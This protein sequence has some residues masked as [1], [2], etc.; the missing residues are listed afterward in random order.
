MKQVYPLELADGSRTAITIFRDNLGDAAPLLLFFPAMGVEAS[1]YQP[2][3]EALALRGWIVISADLRG[4]GHSSV[5]PRRGVDYGYEEMI[6]LDY[7][8]VFAEAEHRFPGHPL[9]VMGHSLGGQLASLFLS[10]YRI[11]TAG[12]VL[13]AACSVHYSGWEWSDRWRLA[14]GLLVFPPVARLWGYHPG[15]RLGFGGRA[16]RQQILDWCRQGRTGQY[17]LLKSGFDYEK[18]LG[19]W[20]GPVLAIPLEGDSF[21]PP[22]AM[23]NLYQKLHPDSPTQVKVLTKEKAKN[24]RLNHFNWARQPEAAID[25][26]EEWATSIPDR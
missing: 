15:H 4:L 23:K 16:G 21:A 14:F 25:L 17:R 9:Y 3:A 1:Y 7:R 13:I 19:E 26:I 2:F 6:E 8:A 20:R 18:A 10:R 11:K 24:P 5:R 22:R 12:L